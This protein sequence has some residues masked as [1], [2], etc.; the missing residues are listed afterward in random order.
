MLK[1]RDYDLFFDV[2]V[3]YWLEFGK[4]ENKYLNYLVKLLSS[5]LNWI[6]LILYYDRVE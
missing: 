4:I 1:L 3:D 6:K 2:I 5:I